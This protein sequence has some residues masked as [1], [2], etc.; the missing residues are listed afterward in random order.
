MTP[1]AKS[2]ISDRTAIA[3]IGGWLALRTITV[4]AGLAFLPAMLASAPWAVPLVRNTATTVLVA[5]SA[6]R[7]RVATLVVMGAASVLISTIGGL[8]LWWTGLRFGAQL[9]ERGERSHA[10]WASIW[11]PKRIER[12]HRWLERWGIL[13]VSL[14]RLLGGLNTPV[15]LVSGSSRMRGA[16]FALAQ[17]I[18]GAAWAAAVIWLGVRA[19]DAWPW[20]P[21]KIKSLSSLSLRIGLVSLVVLV[22]LAAFTSLRRTPAA[23]V[24]TAE[25]PPSDSSS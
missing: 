13:A 18:G 19:G 21:E 11:N 25:V 8:V 5:G 17:A 7:S 20:L 22:A 3:I 14:S 24:Q 9:A 4:R 6:A 23:P 12:G 10:A 15:A 1:E 16:K 2:R